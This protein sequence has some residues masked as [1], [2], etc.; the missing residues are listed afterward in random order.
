MATHRYRIYLLVFNSIS[1]LFSALT[2]ELLS[3]ILEEK[4]HIYMHP[5]I[6]L[7]LFFM[8]K[9]NYK[10]LLRCYILQIQTNIENN[11]EIW[12]IENF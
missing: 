8:E 6:I 11:K 3:W 12:E 10:L 1:R 5:R 4:F 9:N 2:F 7:H